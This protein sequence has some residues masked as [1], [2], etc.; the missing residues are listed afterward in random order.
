MPAP[1]FEIIDKNGNSCME[2]AL[3]E[4]NPLEALKAKFSDSNPKSIREQVAAWAFED[5]DH[6][7]RVI[8]RLE[9]L[10]C[11]ACYSPAPI[12]YHDM[13]AGIAEHWQ[14]IDAALDSYRDATGEAWTPQ[15]D[16]NFLTHLWFAYE[17]T[18]R[19]LADDIRNEIESN[20][21]E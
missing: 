1:F 14:E 15:K 9:E 5:A 7:E 16:Q 3:D 2:N 6:A 21:E 17:W 10:D 12:Y 8:T 13:A 18:A 19:E 20:P 11:A 4:I